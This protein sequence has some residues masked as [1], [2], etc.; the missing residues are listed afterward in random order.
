[1]AAFLRAL[2]SRVTL[3]LEGALCID[4]EA[5]STQP[6]ILTLVNVTAHFA[7]C[8]WKEALVAQATVRT[9]EVLT[10]TVRT[11]AR[12]LTLINVIAGSGTSLMARQARNTLIGAWG[13]LT[14]LSGTRVG[15]QTL[16]YVFT[17]WMTVR[18]APK[19]AV[20]F[21]FIGAGQVHTLAS[22]STDVLLGA[23]VHIYALKSPVLHHVFI[24]LTTE[25]FVASLYVDAEA[26]PVAAR[27]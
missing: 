25:A 15:I 7:V 18:L 22:D 14:L 13:V 4:A 5:I 3:T 1:M 20:T 16:V 17:G 6:D 21:A 12:F 19:T 10:A 27:L 2:V 9:R 11:D 23:L 8:R 26:P 24:A